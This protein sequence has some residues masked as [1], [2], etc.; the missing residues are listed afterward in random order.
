MTKRRITLEIA[1]NELFDKLHANPDL[2][3]ALGKRLVSACLCRSSGLLDAIGF[4]MYGITVVEMDEPGMPGVHVS[5][6]TANTAEHVYLECPQCQFD[7]VLSR[8]EFIQA[9]GEHLCPL[10]AADSGQE[11]RMKSR[12]ATDADKP[13]GYDARRGTVSA[14]GE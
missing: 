8:R 10:C 13:E 12:P 3:R 9:T 7:T 4:A 6:D 11:A 14:G 2:M 5:F 1:S